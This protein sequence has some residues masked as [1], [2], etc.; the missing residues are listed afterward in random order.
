MTMHPHLIVHSLESDL[1]VI[2]KMLTTVPS[3]KKAPR[4]FRGCVD[5]HTQKRTHLHIRTYYLYCT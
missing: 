4:T 2:N 3:F 1:I 5:T